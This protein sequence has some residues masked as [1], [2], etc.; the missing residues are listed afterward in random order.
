MMGR[1]K[2]RRIGPLPGAVAKLKGRGRW[3]YEA[4]LGCNLTIDELAEKAG[5][6]RRTI[7]RIEAGSNRRTQSSTFRSLKKALDL[8]P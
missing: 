6:S 4:R 3:C 5:L 1:E 7:L 2:G 8:I